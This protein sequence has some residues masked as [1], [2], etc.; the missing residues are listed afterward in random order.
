M[1]V[2]GFW[3]SVVEFSS[4]SLNGKIERFIQGKCEEEI[5]V[6][7]NRKIALFS[8]ASVV[9][10][11]LT[12]G[13]ATRSHNDEGARANEFAQVEVSGSVDE[14]AFA[15]LL[16]RAKKAGALAKVTKVSFKP[17]SEPVD[18]L[19]SHFRRISFGTLDV[20]TFD[21]LKK[22]Y[23]KAGGARFQWEPET[24]YERGRE[25]FLE[26]FLT[27]RIQALNGITFLDESA[28]KSLFL[29]EF[30][31]TLKQAFVASGM[32]AADVILNLQERG[33][34]CWSTVWN[35]GM[36]PGNTIEG[37]NAGA[38]VLTELFGLIGN[39]KSD[40]VEPLVDFEEL[41]VPN[42]RE[43]LRKAFQSKLVPGDILVVRANTPGGSLMAH[44]AVAVDDGVF[45]EKTNFGAD[46]AYRF[47]SFDEIF[48]AYVGKPASSIGA[49]RQVQVF[50]SPETLLA[51]P[52]SEIAAILIDSGHLERTT[53]DKFSKAFVVETAS[54]AS[55]YEAFVGEFY[56]IPL[57]KLTSAGSKG[58]YAV[59]VAQSMKASPF[60]GCRAVVTTRSA[61]VQMGGAAPG[62]APFLLAQNTVLSV[63]RILGD[64]L[65]V[66]SSDNGIPVQSLVS[67]S[68][69]ACTTD[70]DFEEAMFAGNNSNLRSAP[71]KDASLVG[72]VSSERVRVL[73]TDASR[74]W[75]YVKT[76]DGTLG[77]TSRVNLSKP[78]RVR[79]TAP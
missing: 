18:P 10:I 4:V 13:C 75:F 71:Q 31:S 11:G 51:F 7:A 68:D 22:E 63:G 45:F 5:S 23:G 40:F 47:T 19:S 14:P 59:K 50:P 3:G 26:D 1:P 66:D 57:E 38:G 29:N 30:S 16:T 15:A 48:D 17:P 64:N 21:A 78:P 73:M 12:G 32:P 58:R 39:K 56:Q 2:G 70:F 49:V 55:M 65:E 24:E 69:V 27:P 74:K 35:I 72:N 37:F 33:S 43:S 76:L 34:N 28:D 53:A 67:Q 25:Y 60:A 77:W 42:S 79:L 52:Q 44:V 9:L 36:A 54:F 41:V 6:I 8:L 61:S 20:K 62:S 46:F